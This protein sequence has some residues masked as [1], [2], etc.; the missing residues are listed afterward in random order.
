M[1]LRQLACFPAAL[2][3][4]KSLWMHSRVGSGFLPTENSISL[5]CSNSVYL[6]IFIIEKQD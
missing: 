2:F 4:C 3:Y 6:S 5:C 1:C